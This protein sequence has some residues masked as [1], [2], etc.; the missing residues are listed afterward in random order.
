M[1]ALDAAGLALPGAGAVSTPEELSWEADYERSIAALDGLMTATVDLECAAVACGLT[2]HA[3]DPVSL[4]ENGW[5]HPV[6]SLE[7]QDSL[8]AER[9]HDQ[10]REREG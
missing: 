8:A 5:T 6:C 7:Y 10:R 3:G 2:I 4:G 1:A 9:A